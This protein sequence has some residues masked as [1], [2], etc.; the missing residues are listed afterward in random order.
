MKLLLSGLR[1]QR[2]E[3][4]RVFGSGEWLI[5]RCANSQEIHLDGAERLVF[6]VIILNQQIRSSIAKYAYK[7]PSFCAA[8]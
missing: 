6:R 5:R 3:R 7:L 8:I 2:P 1:F 4:R